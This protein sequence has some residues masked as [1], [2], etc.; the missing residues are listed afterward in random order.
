VKN[1]RVL[2]VSASPLFA[3]AICRLLEQE[4]ISVVATASSLEEAGLIRKS[5]P[6]DATV[7]NHD[8]TQLQDA[9]VVSELM[10]NQ[11]ARQI[12]FLTLA[13]NQ[14]IVHHRERIENVTPA[15]LIGAIR[16]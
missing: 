10:H 3:D 1:C 4:G 12:V 6:I 2:I 11:E 15:D 13:G 8:D 7:I 16:S 14:M 5:Q 9:A